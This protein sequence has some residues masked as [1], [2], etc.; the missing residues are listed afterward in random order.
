MRFGKQGKLNARF[1]GPFKILK[2]IGQVAYELA[3]PPDLAHVHNVFHMSMLRKYVM[4]PS[5]VIEYEP[6]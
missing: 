6:L 5:H 1:I 4:D 2:K 3:L